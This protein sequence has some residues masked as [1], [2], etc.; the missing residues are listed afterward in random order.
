M[1]ESLSTV[2]A[3]TPLKNR[4]SA[5]LPPPTSTSLAAVV[6][7]IHTTALADSSGAGTAPT[8]HVRRRSIRRGRI[9]G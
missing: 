1:A 7:S 4:R 9:E 3:R 2:A 6:T 8:V 5:P